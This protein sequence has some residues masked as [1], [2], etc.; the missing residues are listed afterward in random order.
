MMRH[1]GRLCGLHA[2]HPG[3]QGVGETIAHKLVKKADLLP[4]NRRT[5]EAGLQLG[6]EQR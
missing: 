1:T 6:R 4:L 2:G 3:E 5:F